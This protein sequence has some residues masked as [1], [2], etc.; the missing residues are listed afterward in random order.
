MARSV[1]KIFSCLLLILSVVQPG[2]AA[3]TPLNF[4][5]IIGDDISW[6][7]FGCY[8]HPRIRTPNI[9]RLA[10]KGIRFDNAYLTAS[11]C[12]PSRASIITGRY[13]HNNGAAAELHR[14]IPSHLALFPEMLQRAGYHT[15]HAGKFHIGYQ[16]RKTTAGYHTASQPAARAFDV[17]GGTYGDKRD[18]EVGGMD[19]WVARLRNRPKDKP[20]FMWFASHDAHRRWHVT[21]PGNPTNRIDRLHSPDDAIVPPYLIDNKATRRDLA[22]YYNEI[23][24]LDFYVGEVFRE[25][26][27]QKLIETTLVIFMADNGRPFARCKGRTYDSGMKTPFIV[28]GPMAKKGAGRISRQLVSAIDLAPT[29]LELAGVK[30]DD[31]MQGISFAPLLNE[32]DKPIRRYVFGE[33]NFHDHAAHERMV[34]WRDYMY[35]RN[36]MPEKRRIGANDSFLGGAGESLLKGFQN[37]TLNPAQHDM[38]LRPRPA[39]ELYRISTDPHQLNNLTDIPKHAAALKHLRQIMDRWQDETG[40]SL[41]PDATPEWVEFTGHSLRGLKTYGQH[42]TPPGGDRNAENINHPGPR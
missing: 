32:P 40:D 19:N 35:L 9:D 18:A 7:D 6:N 36:A 28:N 31:S 27:R 29:L 5:L 8:G 38:Y 3:D 26:T 12:S 23:A 39:E 41:P 2:A 33:H 1:R 4:V 42:G 34:R 25:L 21:D 15:A 11:S 13:P 16:N 14:R 10:A 30:P 22:D 37:G 17:A 20:F 24:R